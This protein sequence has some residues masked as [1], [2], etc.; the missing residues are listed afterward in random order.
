MLLLLP[1]CDSEHSSARVKE[2]FSRPRIHER[3]HTEC[4][5]CATRNTMTP[6]TGT[7]RIHDGNPTNTP[8]G[9]PK[10]RKRMPL[11]PREGILSILLILPV[12]VG[13]WLLLGA[14]TSDQEG[15]A[16][17]AGGFALIGLTVGWAQSV[18]SDRARRRQAVKDTVFRELELFEG[19]IQRRNIGISVVGHYWPELTE[20]RG[21]FVRVLT[22]QAI[23]IVAHGSLDKAHELSNLKRIMTLLSEVRREQGYRDY[24]VEVVDAL[25]K[26][27]ADRRL[28]KDTQALL[29]G[30]IQ[31]LS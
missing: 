4:R 8:L 22:N 27:K 3:R 6:M 25:E 30:W 2:P 5:R 16:R 10:Q 1:R 14:G 20:L 7:R 28:P 31:E 26:G 24:L 19:G 29:G 15:A 18:L 13:A 23:Y 21:I 17:I 9:K 11:T 12:G